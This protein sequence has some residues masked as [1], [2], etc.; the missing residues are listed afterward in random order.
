MQ[1]TINLNTYMRIVLAKSYGTGQGEEFEY[2][3]G[4][5]KKKVFPLP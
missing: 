4:Q 2:E 3:L 5:K 1:I